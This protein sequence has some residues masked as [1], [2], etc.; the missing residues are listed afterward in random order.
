MRA[1]ALEIVDR[2]A[3]RRQDHD[4][5]GPH[6]AEIESPSGAA[7]E[8]STPIS[9]SFAFTCGLWMISPARNMAVGKLLPGLV[10]VLDRPLDPVAEP[11]FPGESDGDVVYRQGIIMRLAGRSTRWPV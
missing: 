9:R 4:V 6:A 1:K 7:R 5:L 2:D 10:G 11:E 8:S 3:E